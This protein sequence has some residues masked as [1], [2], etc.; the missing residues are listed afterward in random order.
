MRKRIQYQQNHILHTAFPAGCWAHSTAK[1]QTLFRRICKN[2]QKKIDTLLAAVAI[3]LMFFTGSW[4][5]LVELAEYGL[6]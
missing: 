3:G 5:F 6:R 4:I 1:K 2:S